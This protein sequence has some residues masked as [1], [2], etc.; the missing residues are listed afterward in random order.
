LKGPLSG[1]YGKGDLCILD[2]LVG[3]IQDKDSQR[4][5]ESLVDVIALAVGVFN[6]YDLG[7]SQGLLLNSPPRMTE[8]IGEILVI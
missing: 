5:F 4:P 8:D 1:F 2:R 3:A 7:C 6:I